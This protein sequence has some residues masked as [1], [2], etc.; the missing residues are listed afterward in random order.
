MRPMVLKI[1]NF[2]VGCLMAFLAYLCQVQIYIWVGNMFLEGYKERLI[3]YAL[4]GGLHQKLQDKNL[5]WAMVMRA[6]LQMKLSAITGVHLLLQIALA[7]RKTVFGDFSRHLK[8]ILDTAVGKAQ[9]SASSLLEM[10]DLARLAERC[11]RLDHTIMSLDFIHM[12]N[13][14]L[15]RNKVLR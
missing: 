4:E 12:I 2:N 13:C 9:S 11:S 14:I 15:L 10:D 6:L 1:M 5:L 3:T 7:L 8:D